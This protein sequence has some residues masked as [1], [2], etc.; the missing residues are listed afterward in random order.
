[1]STSE[2][3]TECLERVRKLPDASAGGPAILAQW[4]S[5]WWAYDPVGREIYRE[6]CRAFGALTV[7]ATYISVLD[8][9][10]P[11][12]AWIY[13]LSVAAE[14]N[15]PIVVHWTPYGHDLAFADVER[16]SP[17]WVHEVDDVRR[18][19][20]HTHQ[21][22]RS[23]ARQIACPFRPAH[24]ALVGGAYEDGR[25]AA[26]LGLDW[27]RV[28]GLYVESEEVGVD[29]GWIVDP[30]VYKECRW[31]GSADNRNRAI[32]V[33]QAACA[34]AFCEGL[35]CPRMPLTA[36]W[37]GAYYW[38]R[39]PAGFRPSSWLPIETEPELPHQDYSCFGNYWTDETA[40]DDLTRTLVFN[41]T[42]TPGRPALTWISTTYD[43]GLRRAHVIDPEVG[44]AK[45]RAIADEDE[46]NIIG[47]Y[48]LNPIGGWMTEELF[49][50]Q[51]QQVEAIVKAVR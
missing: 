20:P 24:L 33:L 31:C 23:A 37:S 21:T 18:F 12:V 9:T 2:L 48:A 14:I 16:M 39:D 7:T 34:R 10:R 29:R 50:A 38:S 1:M 30:A 25:K 4:N 3:Y 5:A 41:M 51:W 17:R 36:W 49:A 27:R 42:F 26:A 46:A 47:L 40:V 28:G 32:A 43:G 11:P 15:L 8:V 45:A 13:P 6:C 35:G 44:R 19:L 22:D